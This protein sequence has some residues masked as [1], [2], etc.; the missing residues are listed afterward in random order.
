MIIQ[1]GGI[2]FVKSTV[3]QLLLINETNNFIWG[4]AKNPWDV[5]RTSGGSSGGESGLVAAGCSPLGL[6][7]DGGGSVRLPANYCGL[8]GFKTTGAR[9]SLIGHKK[10]SEYVPRHIGSALGPLAKNT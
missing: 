8:Y 7:S 2:P 3:P 9:Y 4:R 5:K 10:P 1:G 6:G